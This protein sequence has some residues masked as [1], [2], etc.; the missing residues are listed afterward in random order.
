MDGSLCD[1]ARE[2]TQPGLHISL[3]ISPFL[4]FFKNLF[5]NNIFLHF[6]TVVN[7]H[8]KMHALIVY[9]GVRV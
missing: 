3:I 2:I 8:V 1:K 6:N 5:A 9:V 7:M 4:P